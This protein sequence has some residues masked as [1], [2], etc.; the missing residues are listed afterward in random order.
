MPY[1]NFHSCRIR[2]PHLFEKG[3]FRTLSTKTKGLTFIVGTLKK[4]GKTAV[5]AYRYKKTDWDKK[6]AR[7]HCEKR[8]GR[9]E[10]ASEKRNLVADHAFLHSIFSK[11]KKE[12]WGGWTLDSVIAEHIRITK[13]LKDKTFDVSDE[14][15]CISQIDA[16]DRTKN[17]MPSDIFLLDEEIVLENFISVIP[18]EE[19]LEIIISKIEEDENIEKLVLKQFSPELQKKIKFTYSVTIVDQSL[20]IYDLILKS[21]K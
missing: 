15:D 1:P 12:E 19:H 11:I 13:E 7:T 5:Q 20:P 10:A 4:T 3:S 2:E 18:R 14:L 8:E 6:R 16:L 9:F 21:K 17:K